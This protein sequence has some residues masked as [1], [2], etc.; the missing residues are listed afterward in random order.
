MILNQNP[1]VT[2]IAAVD[3]TGIIG[4]DG[5]IPWHYKNDLKRFKKL[6]TGSTVVMGRMTWESLPKPLSNRRNIVIT[7]QAKPTSKH[8]AGSCEYFTDFVKGMRAACEQKETTDGN[9]WIIGGGEIYRLAL[10]DH[11]AGIDRIDLTL[12][13]DVDQEI[14]NKATTVTEF[15]NNLLDGFHLVNEEIDKED[16]IIH[17]M[18]ERSV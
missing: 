2:I 11:K 7:R 4:V 9:V 14:L 17:R 18:F 16:R 13:D 15:P 12:V 6:T 3:P 10:E 1:K 5:T 8:P